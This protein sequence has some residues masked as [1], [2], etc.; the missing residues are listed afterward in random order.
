MLKAR[1]FLAVILIIVLMAF[2]CPIEYTYTLSADLE[3]SKL[4]SCSS[5][6]ELHVSCSPA[7]VS[8]IK[9][10][11]PY[12]NYW[13][14]GKNHLSQYDFSDEQDLLY[15]LTF[16]NKTQFPEG[17]KM[18]RGFDQKELLEWGK[19]PGLNMDILHK[20]GFTGVG[21]VVAYIDQPLEDHSEYSDGNLHYFDLIPNMSNSMHGPAVLSLLI[22]KNTGTAPDTEVYYL[23]NPAW[24]ADQSTHAECI[25]K[26]ILISIVCQQ[27]CCCA[28][29]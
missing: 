19:Y 26:I 24:L 12:G 21:S 17:N 25:Y 4:A 20:Y 14:K 2:I 3:N 13:Y 16:S 10:V 22:G 28:T 15:T 29:A 7:A 27:F 18:P 6:I 11:E 8:G 23:E 9:G 5:V 1:K